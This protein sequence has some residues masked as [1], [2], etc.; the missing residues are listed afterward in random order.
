[1]T[2]SKCNRL[3]P[4]RGWLLL[5]IPDSQ[6]AARLPHQRLRDFGHF[7]AITTFNVERVLYL[8]VYLC[9][10]THINCTT[11]KYSTYISTLNYIVVEGKYIIYDDLL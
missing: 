4:A 8:N 3:F 1:M 9:M 2:F 5:V 7:H 10:M 11:T 6:T